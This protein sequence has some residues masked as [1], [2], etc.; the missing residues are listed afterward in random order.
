VGGGW[1]GGRGADVD[2]RDCKWCV[3]GC[4]GGCAPSGGENGVPPGA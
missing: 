1:S 2:C 4:G 3:G